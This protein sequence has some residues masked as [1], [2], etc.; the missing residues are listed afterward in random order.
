MAEIYGKFPSGFRESIVGTSEDDTIYPLGGWDFVDGGAGVD[1]TVV[2]AP[3]SS[4]KLASG[5]GVVYLDTLSAASASAEQVVLSNVEFARF[6]D[7]TVSLALPDTFHGQPGTDVFDGGSGLDR[8]V[9]DRP[10]AEH[11]LVRKSGLW[12]VTDLAGDGGKDTLKS[13]ERLEFSDFKVALDL[14]PGEAAGQAALLIGAVLGRDLMLAKRELAGAV[15]GLFDQGYD[16]PTLAGALMRLP[17]WGLLAGSDASADIARY[18]HQRVHGQA[19]NA[20]ELA[21]A[22]SALDSKPQG[23][24]LAGLAGSSANAMQI[25]LVG[26]ANE[27][28]IFL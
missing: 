17:I 3:S 11:S 7:L 5:D 14:G 2:L 24:Y 19:P 8:V 1:T 18:L 9:Y 26:L 23:A 28:L 20:D 10:L 25:D 15:I 16:L 21:A 27:G 6:T 13:I 12:S 22:V 4:F